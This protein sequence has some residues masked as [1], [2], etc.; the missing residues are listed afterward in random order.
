MHTPLIAAPLV[1]EFSVRHDFEEENESIEQFSD[2]V[3]FDQQT[4]RD[5]EIRWLAGNHRRRNPSA[6]ISLGYESGVY[7]GVD[8]VMGDPT[9]LC[10]MMNDVIQRD[11]RNLWRS[12][13][14][15]T[16]LIQAVDCQSESSE[17]SDDSDDGFM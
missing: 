15:E 5:E 9:A 1:E 16:V 4:R 7:G 17:Y 11:C 10:E 3:T 8:S 6:A 12:I 2:A 14:M 13:T